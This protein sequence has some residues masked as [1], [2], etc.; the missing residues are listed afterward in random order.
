MAPTL[1]LTRPHA[2]S[3]RFADQCVAALGNMFSIVIS[4]VIETTLLDPPDLEPYAGVIF[5]SENAVRAAHRVARPIPAYCVGHRTAR[6]AQDAGFNAEVIGGNATALARELEKRSPNGPLLHM[7]GRHQTGNLSHDLTEGGI[8]TYAAIVYDQPEQ[9]LS[10][11]ARL[12]IRGATPLIL[13]M[14]STRSAQ[15]LRAQSLPISAPVYLAALS[16]KVADVW[17][18]VPARARA[19]SA[20]PDADSMIEIIAQL[21]QRVS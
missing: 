5:T 10:T 6:A 17:H 11:D 20:R 21:A 1:L 14:F 16:Q 7:R 3:V 12:A 15:I 9:P 19:V 13:P 2:Q 8:T 4:P 18:D